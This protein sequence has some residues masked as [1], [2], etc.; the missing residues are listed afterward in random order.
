[1]AHRHLWLWCGQVSQYRFHTI[2]QY[3]IEYHA[4]C[5]KLSAADY[6][7]DSRRCLIN[8]YKLILTVDVCSDFIMKVSQSALSAPKEPATA[9]S[10][11]ATATT[12]TA[13]TATR[14]AGTNVVVSSSGS[15]SCTDTAVGEHKRYH[16]GGQ[17]QQ[18]QQQQRNN[19]NNSNGPGNNWWAAT[20]NWHHSIRTH[21]DIHAL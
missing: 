3:K 14:I 12:T 11:A 9:A 16:T 18:Q 17:L 4:I 15:G 7:R 20:S 6:K 2:T 5:I 1:M 19:N 8:Q 13:A 21:I 10:Q